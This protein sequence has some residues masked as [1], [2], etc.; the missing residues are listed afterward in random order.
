MR[1]IFLHRVW[2]VYGG[3]E[4]VTICLANEMARRGIG[5]HVAYFKDSPP[6]KP[7]LHVDIRLKCHRIDNVKFDESSDDFFVD[8][9]EAAYVSSEIVRIIRSEGIDIVHNQW[10][11]VEFLE[12]V[13]GRTGAKVVKVLH[14]DVDTKRA[15][16]FSGLGGVLLKAVYP[17]YRKA[18]KYKNIRRADKYYRNS[19]KFV[20]LA[21]CFMED[22]K[23]LTS[24]HVDEGR[25]DFVFNPLV[26]GGYITEEE[27]ARKR[28]TVL[29]VGRLSERHKKLSRVI[30]L[31]RNVEADGSLDDWNLKMVG[32]GEDAAL[33][34]N[35]ITR[36]GLKR[37]SM[38][39]F[40]QPLPYY[41]EARIFLMTSAYEGWGMTLLEAQQHG[42]VC[43]ALDTYESLHC[44]LCDGENGVMAPD[45]S[46]LW[47]R[48]RQLMADPALLKRYADKGLQTCRRFEVGPVV[49]KWEELYSS[50]A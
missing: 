39:G 27:R 36:Y 5:V 50:M 33:Y 29:V 28:N 18:E 43:A 4:T 12:G 34:R 47:E 48:V 7:G 35:M 45:I 19:D 46:A 40:R 22:Y 3:G 37:V 11:P 15:F 42:V 21:P 20:F 38:E 13:R 1:V 41:K 30:E 9:K 31:W 14:M 16:D 2:P 26:F 24:L 17:A 44:I 25:L 32:G 49:D 8:R 6:D 10:W 23:R